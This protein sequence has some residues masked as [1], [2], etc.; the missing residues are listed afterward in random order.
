MLAR[1]SFAEQF[2]HSGECPETN[3]GLDPSIQVL[4][5]SPGSASSP[6]KKVSCCCKKKDGNDKRRPE[7]LQAPLLG[8]RLCGASGGLADAGSLRRCSGLFLWWDL[9]IRAIRSSLATELHRRDI[10][11]VGSAARSDRA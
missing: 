7:I 4:S 3:L 1:V 8:L 11:R 6:S 5:S 9:S 10:K 2:V